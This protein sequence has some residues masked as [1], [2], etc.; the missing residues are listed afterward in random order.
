MSVTKK[1]IDFATNSTTISACAD[2]VCQSNQLVP[3]KN[4]LVSLYASLKL[5]MTLKKWAEE[6]N[7]SS[8]NIDLRKFI[9][10]GI[11]NGFISRVH[12]YPLKLSKNKKGPMPHTKDTYFEQMLNGQTSV[13]EIC[14]TLSQNQ[15]S[16]DLLLKSD[17]QIVMLSK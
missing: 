8:H 2:Y 16:V 13:D 11:L 4:T 12:K 7:I 9:I 17:N 14:C 10:F 15:D 6:T 1:F 5:D 3:S